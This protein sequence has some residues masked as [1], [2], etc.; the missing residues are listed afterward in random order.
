MP[1]PSPQQEYGWHSESEEIVPCRSEPGKRL[2]NQRAGAAQGME[3]L[4]RAA[5]LLV[6]DT[7]ICVLRLS[8][9]VTG[10][11][12]ELTSNGGRLVAGFRHETRVILESEEPLFAITPVPPLLPHDTPAMLRLRRPESGLGHS[13]IVRGVA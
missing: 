12:L 6:R 11:V 5:L 10:G 9:M 7:S 2:T 1:G 3:S 13:G 4:N 8:D